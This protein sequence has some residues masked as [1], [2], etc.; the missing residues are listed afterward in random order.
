MAPVTAPESLLYSP[1]LNS[2]LSCKW[3]T[4]PEETAIPAD[5]SI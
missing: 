5:W 4:A 3:T 2:L 1:L